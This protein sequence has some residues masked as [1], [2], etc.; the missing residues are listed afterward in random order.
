MLTL[1]LILRFAL[2][3]IEVFNALSHI[4]MNGN[5]IFIDTRKKLRKIIGTNRKCI[6][7]F[8]IFLLLN[9]NSLLSSS[10]IF[11]YFKWDQIFFIRFC[12]WNC[13]NEKI[14]GID[15]F[16]VYDNK[17][18]TRDKFSIISFVVCWQHQKEI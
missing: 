17:L 12:F 13:V 14:I 3:Q 5:P 1:D 15:L 9:A 10:L 6:W 7:I 16:K 8:F 4:W 18:K 2:L 11:H